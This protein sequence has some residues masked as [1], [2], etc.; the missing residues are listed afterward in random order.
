[1]KRCIVSNCKKFSN[2]PFSLLSV[3]LFIVFG[4]ASCSSSVTSNPVNPAAAVS[5]KTH[6]AVSTPGL[7]Q[8][9]ANCLVGIWEIKDQ[10]SYLSSSIPVGAFE[11]NDLKFISTTG[12]VGIRFFDNGVI[13]VQADSFSGR[14]DVSIENRIEILEIKMNGFVNGQYSLDGDRLTILNTRQNEMTYNA[15]LG[16]E[17]MMFEKDARKFLPL[18][19]EPYTI[20]DINCNAETLT[21]DIINFPSNSGPLLFTRLR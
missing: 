9:S 19:I 16:D 17:M 12:S 21:I 14:F 18:F 15:T 8:E 4:L 2:I 13:A 5:S 10:K 3:S 7:T 6:N 20:A 1:M 11:L